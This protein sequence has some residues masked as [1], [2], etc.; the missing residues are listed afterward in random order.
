[1]CIRDMIEQFEIQGA[2]HIKQ[3]DNRI[4]DCVT[5]AKG[6][7]FE[8]E[9]YDIDSEVLGRRIAYMY[10]VDDVLNIEIE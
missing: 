9:K 3:W 1:M 6:K 2:Y 8:I 10:V 4:C 7:D 5:V